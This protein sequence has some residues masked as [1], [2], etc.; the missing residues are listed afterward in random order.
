MKNRKC[1]LALSAQMLS[2]IILF[3]LFASSGREGDVCFTRGRY[4]FIPIFRLII[5]Q[6]ILTNIK[7]LVCTHLNY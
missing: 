6:D 2:N 1:V 5:I 4:C 7:S 3:A